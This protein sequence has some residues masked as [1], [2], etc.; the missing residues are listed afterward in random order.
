MDLIPSHDD[1]PNAPTRFLFQ[2]P[3]LRLRPSGHQADQCAVSKASRSLESA[4]FYPLQCGTLSDREEA[5]MP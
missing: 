2:R 5:W 1:R 4:P 3:D